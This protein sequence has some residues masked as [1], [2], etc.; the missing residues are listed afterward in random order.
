M[1]PVLPTVLD[2]PS[3]IGNFILNYGV[4][5]W[6][7][8]V[9]LE[10][11]MPPD[12]FAEIKNEHFQNPVKRVKAFVN[13]AGSSHEQRIA[14]ANFFARLD[15]IRILRNHIAH[16]HFL[17]RMAEDGKTL[18]LTVSLPKDLDATY[19]SESKHLEFKELVAAMSELTE[20]IEEFQK[21]DGGWTEETASH[22]SRAH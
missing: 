20:L 22:P 11:R 5:D 10:K 19:D 8:F 12:Q 13:A 17:V 15:P 1:N 16:G 2:W 21:L 18:V 14:F 9:F 3:A 4:L 6:H 7:L